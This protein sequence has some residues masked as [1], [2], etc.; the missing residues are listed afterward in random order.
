MEWNMNENEVLLES[1]CS[2]HGQ[3]QADK[4]GFILMTFIFL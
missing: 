1:K 3:I 4:R 2:E